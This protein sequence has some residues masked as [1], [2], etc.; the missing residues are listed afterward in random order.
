MSL[1]K[2]ATLTMNFFLV[3]RLQNP[4]ALSAPRSPCSLCGL[5]NFTEGAFHWRPTAQRGRRP[6]QVPGAALLSSPGQ[7]FW[8]LEQN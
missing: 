2:T 1:N 5:R 4:E 3:K 7:R 8:D 6:T